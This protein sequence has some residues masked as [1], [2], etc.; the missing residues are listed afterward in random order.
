MS[1]NS[2]ERATVNLSESE[3]RNEGLFGFLAA[4]AGALRESDTLAPEGRHST[5]LLSLLE[6]HIDSLIAT[7]HTLLVQ[8]EEAMHQIYRQL[9][10]ALDAYP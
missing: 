8:D 7:E 6:K 10:R 4:L 9:K 3:L 2:Q 5:A 1:R